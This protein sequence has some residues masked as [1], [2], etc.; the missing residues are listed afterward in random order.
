MLLLKCDKSSKGVDSRRREDPKCRFVENIGS[1]RRTIEVKVGRAV[2][3]RFQSQ[4]GEG[5]PLSDGLKRQTF[6]CRS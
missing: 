2:L 6:F 1:K 4:P 5:D 3:N